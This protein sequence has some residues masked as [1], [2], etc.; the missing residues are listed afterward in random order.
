MAL[1]NCPECKK[2]VSDKSDVCIHC[3]FPIN[4]VSKT[5]HEEVQPNLQ[6]S[7]ENDALTSVIKNKKKLILIFSISIVFIMCICALSPFL[8][9]KINETQQK[10]TYQN[11]LE[12]QNSGEYDKALL[13]YQEV[14]EFYPEAENNILE[15]NYQLAII[16]FSNGNYEDSH[17]AFHNI[18][19]YKDSSEHYDKCCYELTNERFNSED[20]KSAVIYLEKIQNIDSFND[21]YRIYNKVYYEAGKNY[22]YEGNLSQALKCFNTVSTYEDS[23]NYL[24]RINMYSKLQGTWK[25]NSYHDIYV[26][27]SGN[28]SQTTFI[29]KFNGEKTIYS[30]LECYIDENLVISYGR[31]IYKDGKLIEKSGDSENVYSRQSAGV[32]PT[33]PYIGMSANEVETSTWGKPLKI[34]KTIT[35]SIVYEQWCYSNDRYIYLKNG[36]VYSIQN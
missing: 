30:E 11:A 24:D 4:E 31:Y 25:A 8:Q 3:G 16:D 22:Y 32:I 21:S 34:N 5:I 12:Y 6:A 36:I 13:L 35:D 18:L 23:E 20:Y 2:E 26:T 1:I 17:N 27:F 19:T 10:N 15:C 28:K 9:T 14:V 33:E 29:N 7:I